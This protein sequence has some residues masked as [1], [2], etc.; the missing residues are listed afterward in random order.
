[1][2]RDHARIAL[3]IWND[4]DFCALSMAA[5][6]VYLQLVTQYKLSYAGV[7]DLA[8][9]RW[10]RPHPDLDVEGVRAALSELDAAR[11]IVT[12]WETEEVLIR[13]FIRNDELYKQPNMVR[14]A[15]RVAFEIES[16]IL[17]AALAV[18]LRRL[19]VEVTGPAPAVAA[20]ALEAGTRELPPV[21]KAAM[22]TKAPARPAPTAPAASV[23]STPDKPGAE[24]SPNPSPNPSGN[25]L[26]K[27]LGEGSR[28]RETGEPSLISRSGKV[29][30]PARASK[31]SR[32][33]P[34]AEDEPASVRQARR[35][36]ARR[37]VLTHSPEQPRRVLDRLTAE[38][39]ELLADGVE[40]AMIGAGLRVWARKRLAVSFLPELVGEY[41]RGHLAASASPAKIE[42][43]AL[44][45]A[46]FER[47]RASAIDRGD[48][49][50]IGEA[51][52]GELPA[53][54]TPDELD[55][56]LRD[57]GTRALAGAGA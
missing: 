40:P 25:P 31:T 41:M 43:D 27:D 51:V 21:V 48:T 12:D 46:T 57:A 4:D 17:R 9:K 53:H 47:V 10:A 45:V 2:A 19:P 54:T 29:G 44:A 28:E 30:V 36:D 33:A 20:D 34:A 26:P 24:G 49:S 5:K 6:L 32:E 52:R 35:S 22:G 15:L 42:A 1:M 39:I 8:A 11:F 38:V 55:A 37:L 50:P 14:A 18:E 13:S 7:L 56:L 3:S 23:E 16:P